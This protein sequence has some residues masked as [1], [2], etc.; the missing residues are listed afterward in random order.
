MSIFAGIVLR[1]GSAQISQETRVLLSENLSRKSEDKI[2]E[3]S[4]DNYH[5]VFCDLGA[6]GAPGYIQDKN[7][8]T[9]LAG[10]PLIERGDTEQSR[11]DDLATI[12]DAI[13]NNEFQGLRDAVGTFCAA[14]LDVES[15]KISLVS[16]KIGLRPIYYWI[17]KD[18]IV[19]ATALRLLEALPCVPKRI[20][21][22]GVTE[23][24][25]FGFPLADRTP[26]DEVRTIRES[27]IIEIDAVAVKRTAY[28]RWDDL[29]SYSGNMVDAA[30]KARDTFKEGVKRRMR[31][32]ESVSAFLSGGLDS[33]VVVSCLYDIGVKVFTYNMS[34]EDS[35]DLIYG[36]AAAK[37]FGCKHQEI[38]P[39]YDAESTRYLK[40]D[41]I[42][43]IQN[44]DEVDA[45][46]MRRSAIWSG[47]GGSVS[48]GYVYLTESMINATRSADQSPAIREY[49]VH[50]HISVP[51][52][53]LS[54]RRDA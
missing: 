15:G 48:V 13:A 28:W 27:E 16:D 32:D 2:H 12:R 29:P 22:R 7:R 11:L 43:H 37:V 31:T 30:N 18:R 4:G 42:D 34:D 54:N 53:I 19:F 51:T 45:G 14:S 36:R 9:V 33:R 35:Q 40:S 6:F 39:K 49:L 26:Y 47:D 38:L 1:S 46:R 3:F 8:L 21:Y 50:N 41:I 52:R 25:V 10:E 23:L 44:I 17:D 5:I 20:N 24:A